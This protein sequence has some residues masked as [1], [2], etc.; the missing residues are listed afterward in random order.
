MGGRQEEI[1]P[2]GR[3]PPAASLALEGGGAGP[4]HRWV[5][6]PGQLGMGALGAPGPVP[7]PRPAGH[8]GGSWVGAEPGGQ[9]GSGAWHLPSPLKPGTGT[10]LAGPGSARGVAATSCAPPPPASWP[11][12]EVGSGTASCQLPVSRAAAP[13]PPHL[14]TFLCTT[15]H[16]PPGQAQ[17]CQGGSRGASLGGWEGLGGSGASRT[18]GLGWATRTWH[19][20][21]S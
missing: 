8:H 13:G 18:K 20:R 14:A 15:P 16:T 19:G 17:P 11:Q 12:R 5:T 6:V 21:H 2:Q 9:P 10:G 3:C 7:L 4:S 1:C